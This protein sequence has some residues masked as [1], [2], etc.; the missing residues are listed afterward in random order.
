MYRDMVSCH[1]YHDAMCHTYHDAMYHT[2]RIRRGP[3]GCESI[4]V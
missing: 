3:S 4:T 2:Y 1:T